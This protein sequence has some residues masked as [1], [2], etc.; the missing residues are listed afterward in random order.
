[1]KLKRSLSHWTVGVLLTAMFVLLPAS[2]C[3]FAFSAPGVNLPILM[4]HHIDEAANRDT[5]ISPEHFEAVVSKLAEQG[6]ESVTIEQVIRYVD[7]GVSLPEKPVLITFDDGYE[8]VVLRAVPVLKSHG[9]VAAAFVIGVSVG[10]DTYKD[11]SVPI[12][13][14]FAWEQAATVADTLSVQSHTFDMHQVP[15]FDTS[16]YRYGVSK[17]K[18]EREYAYL[19]ELKADFTKS[20]KEIQMGVGVPA[21]AVAYPHG[22]KTSESEEVLRS[23]GV[24]MTLTT[25]PGVSRIISSNEESLFS[26]KRINV[27]EDLSPAELIAA[28]K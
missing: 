17:R 21:V 12:T 16:E 5:T 4:F 20:L 25:I 7:E 19:D 26:L 28:M 11:T 18:G 2:V 10:K 13:P 22:Q 27:T 1:M 24:R 23:L 15:A 6:Y 14:H 8:S 9:M 3:I